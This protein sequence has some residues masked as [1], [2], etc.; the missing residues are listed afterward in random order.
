[1]LFLVD[2]KNGPWHIQ[3]VES[4]HG[5][6]G[7]GKAHRAQSLEPKGRENKMLWEELNKGMGEDCSAGQA[8][9]ANTVYSNFNRFPDK[10]SFYAFV[11]KEG[12]EA[13]AIMAEAFDQWAEADKAKR[14]AQNALAVAEVKAK[15]LAILYGIDG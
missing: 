15:K 7:Q 6:P 8:E 5:P 11:K 4:D 2:R 9:Q 14:E 12:W 3:G 1:M 13:V 10:A